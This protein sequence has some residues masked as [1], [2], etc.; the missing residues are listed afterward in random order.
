MYFFVIIFAL[1]YWIIYGNWIGGCLVAS[2]FVILFYSIKKC[3]TE[4]KQLKIETSLDDWVITE[5]DSL[6]LRMKIQGI[7]A[8]NDRYIFRLEYVIE[9]KLRNHKKLKRKKIIWNPK[10]GDYLL[11]SE[12]IQECDNYNIILKSISW[13]DLTGLYKVKKQ[14]NQQISFL[15]M[16]KRYEMG[17]MDERIAKSDLI[18]QGFEYDGVRAYQRGDRISRVHWNL[19]ASTGQLWVRKNE[20]EKEERLKIGLSFDDIL[21]DRLSDYFAIFYSVSWFLLTHGICQ[22][23]Y[24]GESSFFLSHIE[25][26]EE[27]FTNIFCKESKIPFYNKKEVYEIPLCDKEEDVQK[28]IYNME[29]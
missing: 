2:L 29:L 8:K 24:Y 22:E 28:F 16:P 9:K 1:I 10:I 25:Q 13:E 18:E 27:L 17:T 21:K 14:F 12:K 5:G 11:L 4:E 6:N 3:K 19:Y 23:I 26:Y 20:D 15:V 7:S